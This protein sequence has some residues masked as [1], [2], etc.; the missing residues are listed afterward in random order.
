M[1]SPVIRRAERMDAPVHVP[2]AIVGAG[3]C[4]LTAALML[5]DAGIECVVLE[6]DAVPS[7]STALSSGF[8]PAP[9]TR[10]QQSKNIEDSP[11]RFAADIQAK[12]HGT[13]APHLATA[14]AE[15]IGPAMNALQ[16]RHGLDFVLLDDFLYPG[17]SRH[18]MHAVPEKTGAGLMA[19]LQQAAETADVP[20][21]TRA[22]VRELW[23]NERD[24]VLGVAY[25]RPDGT[26][27]QLSCDVLVLACNG[28]GGNAAM[29]QQL[30]P[31]MK[32]ATF[33][34]HT[35]ND[36]SAIAWGRALGARLADL[37]GY[38]GHGSWAVP[39]G[40]LV[41][42]ALMMEG[43]VQINSLGRRFHDETG[44]YSE[45]AVQVLAQP[46]S[47]AWNVFD[48]ALL[49]F[50]RSFPDFCE[51]EVAGALKRCDDETALA[52]LIGCDAA[53]L[54][55]TLAAVT[56]GAAAPDGRVFKRALHTPFYAVK[57]TGALFHTQGGL[58]IDAHCHV[59]HEDASPFKNLL[60]AGG[61]ARGVSGNAVWGY[62]SGNG[63]L[64]AIAG[65][66][67]AARSA[68]T[69]LE[70]KP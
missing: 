63:L 4:G 7:G 53:A 41:S 23:L 39:Q 68:A 18:R 20:I 61:A 21:V 57:V 28:F 32:D 43:A 60:A 19:R 56:P 5:R 11:Q 52:A 70:T 36:G 55:A 16:G 13:A 46:G 25:E 31:E 12:A 22:L 6:R 59:L 58:D 29:V 48:E 3:A 44:G 34:G 37:G 67:I 54:R 69:L 14:Y 1:S 30:L 17:H 2:V 15:A 65:G 40:A 50:A 10:V 26:L 38:Q 62:L 27:E 9:N 24:E 35:G 47:V 8:V 51:A 66:Y 45:A 64:S 33:A 49:A 42:W